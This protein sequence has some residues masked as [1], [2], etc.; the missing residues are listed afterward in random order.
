MYCDI[1][2]PMTSGEKPV[3]TLASKL[4]AQ[5]GFAHGKK[6]KTFLHCSASGFST[7]LQ[8]H[9]NMLAST[10][11]LTISTILSTKKMCV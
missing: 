4:T 9:P 11:I 7:A 8:L 5:V 1:N 3:L 10:T 6:I 2:Y